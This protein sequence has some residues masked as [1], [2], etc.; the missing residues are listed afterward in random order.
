MTK[1]TLHGLNHTVSLYELKIKIK[2]VLIRHGIFVGSE[3]DDI[4]F[5]YRYLKVYL[6]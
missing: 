2:T 4:I 5:F 1:F 6:H 3:S